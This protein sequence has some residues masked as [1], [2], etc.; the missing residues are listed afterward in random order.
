[1]LCATAFQT[2]IKPIKANDQSQC[3]IAG[4]WQ[5]DVGCPYQSARLYC[6]IGAAVGLLVPIKTILTVLFRHNAQCIVGYI[7]AG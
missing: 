3:V 5:I 6:V 1:M 7:A 4:F 2:V